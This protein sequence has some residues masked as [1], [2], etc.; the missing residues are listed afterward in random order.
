MAAGEFICEE[1]NEASVPMRVWVRASYYRFLPYNLIFEWTK[2]ALD[3]YSAE[4][5]VP[6][7]FEKYDQ[8][9]VPEFNM[10]AM[11][12][13]GCVLLSD[14][15][16]WK[17]TPTI[18]DLHTM[19][20]IILH[21]LAHMWF[22]NLVT[23]KWWDDLWLN[24]SFATYMS[25]RAEHALGFDTWVNFLSYKTSAYHMDRMESTHSVRVQVRDTLEAQSI[26]D[27]ITYGK[28]SALVKQLVFLIGHV[29]FFKGL[30]SYFTT[31]AWTNVGFR[32]FINALQ[33]HCRTINLNVWVDEWISMPGLNALS[34]ELRGDEVVISQTCRSGEHF[35]NHCFDLACY[36]NTAQ[37]IKVVRILLPSQLSLTYNLQLPQEASAVIPNPDDHCFFDIVLDKKTLAKIHDGAYYSQLPAITRCVVLN[38]LRGMLEHYE[39]SALDMLNHALNMLVYEEIEELLEVLLSGCTQAIAYLPYDLRADYSHQLVV[40]L[41]SKLHGREEASANFKVFMHKKMLAFMFSPNDIFNYSDWFN[42]LR[43]SEKWQGMM[44]IASTLNLEDVKNMLNTELQHDT[45][46]AS[47]LFRRYCEAAAVDNKHHTWTE[48]TLNWR[49]YRRTELE[50]MMKGFNRDNQREILKDFMDLYFLIVEEALAQADREYAEN[51]FSVMHPSWADPDELLSRLNDIPSSEPWV[52]RLLNEA[53]CQLRAVIRGQQLVLTQLAA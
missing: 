12:N 17:D 4:F 42:T 10:G 39:I 35:R 38:S 48:I 15:I 30:K 32:D 22:G 46:D 45:S 26:L 18:A 53:R 40:G 41:E 31:H 43:R 37:L 1:Y 50:L 51:F 9:F 21:E 23:L 14:R 27:S 13:S 36:D 44:L 33:E 6:F 49:T 20:N 25:Y 47:L 8:V 52:E 5:Q 28:G 3:Y 11:E 29:A 7:P 2:A 24:E 34:C 16:I 19:R